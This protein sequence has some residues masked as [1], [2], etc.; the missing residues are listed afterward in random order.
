MALAVTNILDLKRLSGLVN[1]NPALEQHGM[2]M[3]MKVILADGIIIQLM[4]TYQPLP[5]SSH[6]PLDTLVAFVWTIYLQ[7]LAASKEPVTQ[8]RE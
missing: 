3:A 7:D 1:D 4:S 6:S 8:V 2:T 5:S